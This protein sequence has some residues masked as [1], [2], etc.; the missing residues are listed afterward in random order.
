M[1]LY[2]SLLAALLVG[3]VTTT[4]VV[5]TGLDTYMIS[6]ANDAC[7]NCTPA[8]MRVAQQASDY[9]AKLSRAMVVKDIKEDT[10]DIGFGHR[11]TLTFV[12][13]PI[14]DFDRARPPPEDPKN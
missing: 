3:C 2:F 10:F 13:A 12:C 4:K 9:C 5:P 7:G 11:L 6:A 14:G 8:R 1:R